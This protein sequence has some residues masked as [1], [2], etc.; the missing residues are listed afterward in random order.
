MIVGAQRHQRNPRLQQMLGVEPRIGDRHQ[1]LTEHRGH[2]AGEAAPVTEID[3]DV[4]GSTVIGLVAPGLRG[5]RRAALS[6][7]GDPPPAELSGRQSATAPFGLLCIGRCHTA[8]HV[9]Q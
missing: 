1:P 3:I 4:K 8:Q 6:Q 2:G 7:L 5:Q 9:G